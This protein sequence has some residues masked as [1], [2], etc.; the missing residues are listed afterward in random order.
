MLLGLHQNI[1]VSDRWVF[2]R[3]RIFVDKLS[4]IHHTSALANSSPLI[5]KTSFL[6]LLSGGHEKRPG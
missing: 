2:I 3:S 5:G 4:S 1:E 6:L